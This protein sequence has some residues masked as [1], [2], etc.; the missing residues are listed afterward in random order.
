MILTLS[1]NFP[2]CT[3][4]VG[5]TCTDLAGGELGLAT[6]K[7]YR[8]AGGSKSVNK[9]TIDRIFMAARYD[10]D[11]GVD[12]DEASVVRIDIYG[13]TARKIRRPRD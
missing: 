11:L 7:G 3:K 2:K 8:L 13:E 6:D 5:D 10:G 1:T 12:G 4:F 9:K